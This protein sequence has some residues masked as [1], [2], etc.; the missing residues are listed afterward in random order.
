[1]AHD[2]STRAGAVIQD[3]SGRVLEPNAILTE[4]LDMDPA[5]HLESYYSETAI[6]Y[7]PGR[8]APLGVIFAA[9]KD[10]DGPNDRRSRLSRPGIFRFAFQL[11]KPIY[12]ERFG[13]VPKRPEKGG[14]VR[15][16][17]DP[18]ALNEL[19]PHPVYAWMRWV[20]VL[21]PTRA[22]FDPLMPVLEESLVAVRQRWTQR[23]SKR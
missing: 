20:Q 18:A 2:T 6:F 11:P 1:L 19:T 8:S 21:S 12:I 23:N 9:I 22:T 15:L 14:V 4:L 7:N 3:R 10:H 5:L 17:S 13:S 16:D